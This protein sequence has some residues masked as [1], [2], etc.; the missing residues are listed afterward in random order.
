MQNMPAN[1]KLPFVLAFAQ[2]AKGE[3]YVLTALQS[4]RNAVFDDAIYMIKA[5]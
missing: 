1:N 2:D 5:N 3:V 4:K